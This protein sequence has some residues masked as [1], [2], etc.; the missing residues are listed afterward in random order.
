METYFSEIISFLID[1]AMGI[2]H[3]PAVIPRTFTKKVLMELAN[4]QE[5]RNILNFNYLL[6]NMKIRIK[7]LINMMNQLRK[8]KVY[9][10][11]VEQMKLMEVE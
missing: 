4:E 6:I 10:I 7:K 3:T 8:L 2:A 5:V 1:R 9:L 11:Y